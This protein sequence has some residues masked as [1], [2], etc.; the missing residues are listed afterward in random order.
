MTSQELADEVTAAMES[1]RERIL[2][3]GHDQYNRDDGYQHIET[4]SRSELEMVATEK[5]DD[6][7]VY[8]VELRRRLG[9]LA[10]MQRAMTLN[11]SPK[12][13]DEADA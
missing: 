8:L 7:L 2:T 13:Q 4:L 10:V 6:C 1:C 5:I 9:V 3:V 12:N 11:F